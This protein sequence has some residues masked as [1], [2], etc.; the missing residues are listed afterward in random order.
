[1]VSTS[2]SR[3]YPARRTKN[4]LVVPEECHGRTAAHGDPGGQ[5][6]S[7]ETEMRLLFHYDLE[8]ENIFAS[9]DAVMR[10]WNTI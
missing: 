4:S 9:K 6:S 7:R 5:P 2:Q 8:V 3:N 10:V 1:M